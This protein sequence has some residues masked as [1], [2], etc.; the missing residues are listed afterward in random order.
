ML[1]FQAENKAG[2]AKDGTFDMDT[3][4]AGILGKE[5]TDTPMEQKTIL[6]EDTSNSLFQSEFVD[7]TEGSAT[8]GLSEIFNTIKTPLMIAAGLGQDIGTKIRENYLKQNKKRT[9]SQ[10]NRKKGGK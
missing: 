1:K 4:L 9:N 7:D 2:A 10:I 8:S 3:L 5:Q 6:D